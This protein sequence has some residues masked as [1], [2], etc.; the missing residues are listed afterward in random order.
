[1]CAFDIVC[2]HAV[3]CAGFGLLFPEN[4]LICKGYNVNEMNH[5]YLI[6]EVVVS[7]NSFYVTLVL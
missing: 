2:V 4:T 7:G 3:C 6:S 5:A 1:M